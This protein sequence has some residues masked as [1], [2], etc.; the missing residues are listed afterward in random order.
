MTNEAEIIL[1]QCQLVEKFERVCAFQGPVDVVDIKKLKDGVEEY[2][3]IIYCT[4]KKG[5]YDSM[6]FCDEKTCP[7][8]KIAR[9]VGK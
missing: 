2:H 9:A 8:L 1:T 5:K 7:I 3:T 4:L 6:N